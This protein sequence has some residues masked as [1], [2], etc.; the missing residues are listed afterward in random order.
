MSINGTPVAD[1]T[2]ITAVIAGHTHTTETPSA[3]GD[4]T[5]VLKIVPPVAVTYGAGTPITFMINEQ[6][7]HQTGTWET[8]GNI[9]LNLSTD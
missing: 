3:Y 2:V 8:G 1:G 6:V 4:S 9:E 7:A 5:Y